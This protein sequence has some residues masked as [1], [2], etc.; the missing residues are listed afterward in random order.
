LYLHQQD[1][2]GDVSVTLT[3]P[4][5]CISFK[6]Y[7]QLKS[8]QFGL[9]TFATCESLS[10]YLWSSIFYT[11]NETIMDSRF[12]NTPKA[13]K[14]VIKLPAA[15]QWLYT[16]WKDNYYNFPALAKFLKLCNTSLGIRQSKHEDYAEETERQ[17]DAETRGDSAASGPGFVM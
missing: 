12:K 11:G 3:L 1:N 4:K 5:G 8:S 13:T 14:I 9:K 6:E 7:L 2:S 15:P 10:G 16:L 17:G